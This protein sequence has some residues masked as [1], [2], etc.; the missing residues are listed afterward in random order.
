MTARTNRKIVTLRDVTR[1]TVA[2]ERLCK[3]VSAETISRNN[4]R[5]V[6]SVCSFA[7]GLLNERRRLFESVKFRDASLPGYELGN[8]RFELKF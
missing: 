6:F 2:M 1:I 7:E 3:H 8:R 4:R 5:A